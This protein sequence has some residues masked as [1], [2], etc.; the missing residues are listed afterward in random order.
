MG[1]LSRARLWLVVVLGIV[2]AQA[3]LAAAAVASPDDA[4]GITNAGDNL[5]TGWYPEE[6]SLTPSLVKGNTFGRLWTAE[7][8]GQ[9]YAQPLLADGTLVV[10]TEQNRVYGLDPKTGAQ[11]WAQPLN[12][13][14][15]WNPDDIG[16]G[17]LTPS[18]GV[19]S[20]PVFDPATH[21][22]Y[23]THKT[24]ASGSSG[25]ARWFMDA[26]N[27]ETGHEQPGF[28]LQL[29]GA[30][31][32][33]P[34]VN[35]APTTE[36]Q[37]PGLLLLDGVVYAAFGG[38]CDIRPWRGWI[39]GVST[40]T[41]QV[42]SRWVDNQTAEGGGIWQSGAGLTSDGP[43]TILLSTGNGGAP[44]TP[45]P[46]NTP[47]ANLGESIVRLRVQ[48][49]GELKPVD[50]FAPF[51]AQQLDESD[52]DFAS[53]GVTGL[54]QEYFGTSALPHLAVA[55]GKEG[56][57]YLLDRD[58]LG[59][60]RQGSGS[61]DD[62]VQRLG[63]F[64]GVWSRP[65]VWPGDGGYVYIP[66]SAGSTFDVY[67]YGL[68]GTGKP[69]L[70]R[71]ATAA[72]GLGS[73]SG[74]PVITSDGTTS[75]SAIVWLTRTTDRTGVGAQL[76][77]FE[78]VPAGGKLVQ[79]FNAPIGTASNYSV[80]GVGA[81][82][83]YVGNR[84]GKVIAFGSPVTPALTG[85][86]VSFGTVTTGQSS[87]QTATLT[88]TESLTLTGLGSSS[89]QYVLGSPSAALPA[90]LVAGQ[91]IS[92]PITFSPSGAGLIGGTLTARTA[93]GAEVTVS[94]SGTGRQPAATL[95][96]SPPVV[97]FGGTAIGGHLT[98]SLTVRNDGGEPLTITGVNAPDA[99]FG[100]LGAPAAGTTV[101]GGS[102]LSVTLEFNPTELGAFNGELGLETTAGDVTVPLTGAAGTP[103]H[104]QFSSE[105]LDYGP[106]A[107]GATATGSFTIENT[108]GTTV[109]INKSKPPV[110]GDF[111]ATTTLP[112]GETIE[113]GQSLVE[114][115]SF[116][117]SGT[118]SRTGTWLINGD[119]TTGLHEVRF[120][121]TGGVPEPPS[122]R[123]T[124][125]VSAPAGSPQASTKVTVSGSCPGGFTAGPLA[126]GEPV[127]VAPPGAVAGETCAV[128]E[129]A[130]AGE[131]GSWE[132]VAVIDGAAPLTL[133][134]RDG[135]FAIPA[136]VLHAGV[137]AI[138]LR[139]T[140]APP[141]ASVG[142][143]ASP[144]PPTTHPQAKHRR[145]HRHHRRKH[146]HRRHHRSHR[147]RHVHGKAAGG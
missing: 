108:G 59:G 47:P 145:K 63:P 118:G 18:I 5:R 45:T 138:D 40:Q 75:G 102:S 142:P 95:A 28:P 134:E 8:E 25:T 115:V 57:V 20:T 53:G 69:S 122:L 84:E 81:G 12:L 97:S 52:A 105:A 42:T 147:H 31:Q 41:G 121:G 15:P 7:V 1:A 109:T 3:V 30:A 128:G 144:P 139:E 56:Y 60:Y 143:G 116:T 36:L 119:D 135:S 79:I 82:R 67:K 74:A 92:V 61:G 9:V 140:W 96:V 126:V 120:S 62:V 37:R 132:V 113:P 76:R 39:F 55:V 146:R 10:A 29:S 24:Y 111:A 48:P 66:T 103:G 83:I 23:M 78:A 90:H 43:G 13:G 94:L 44:S 131:G 34:G 107:V 49:N 86:A 16:C 50:F 65:A 99:P 22:M 110:G 17:D 58:D 100:V 70:S 72:E 54:P 35:F 64:G 137:N 4:T 27:V 125:S 80:P 19:T 89:S 129:A 6:A 32:N 104:L 87:T 98:E 133:A 33:A 11:K 88:A 130:P 91:S 127:T 123:F 136:F 112:E 71:V 101:A 46:G 51:D 73:G 2:A 68:T 26:V 85:S 21:T 93:A 77:A 114:T 38:H 117:P 141:A 106:L 14:T 124:S